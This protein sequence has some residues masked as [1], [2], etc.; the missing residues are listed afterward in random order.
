MINFSWNYPIVEFL[1]A[2]L[3]KTCWLKYYHD[4]TSIFS[5]IFIN[6][7][8]IILILPERVLIKWISNFSLFT[9]ESKKII[10]S[11]TIVDLN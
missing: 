7:K 5:L 6:G 4:L 9:D 2:F 10:L 11:G 1:L 3:L 8:K